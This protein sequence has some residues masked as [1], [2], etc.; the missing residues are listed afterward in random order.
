MNKTA[1]PIIFIGI[2][3]FLVF[4]YIH[5]RSSLIK[6]SYQKQKFEKKKAQLNQKKQELKQELHAS[7]DL[8]HIKNFAVESQMQKISLNQIKTAPR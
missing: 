2:Q 1:F 3:I 5:H 4:F 7:H 6:L 8:S